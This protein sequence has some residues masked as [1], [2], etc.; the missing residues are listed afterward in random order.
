MREGRQT[1]RTPCFGHRNSQNSLFIPIAMGN[2]TDVVRRRDWRAK[3]RGN[4][5]KTGAERVARDGIAPKR[6]QN[7]AA[8][9]DEPD[10]RDKF[11]G[12]LAE[13]EAV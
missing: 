6:P 13:R 9:R 2:R 5:A 12:W 3:W 4:G 1:Q 11:D 8:K 10:V 7:C